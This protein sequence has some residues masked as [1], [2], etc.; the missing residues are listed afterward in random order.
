MA[1]GYPYS[2]PFEDDLNY[3][4]NAVKVVVDAYHGD[5]KFYVVDP[6]D[7]ILRVYREALPALFTDFDEV[8]DD[9]RRH[10]RYPI[11]LFDIQAEKYNIYHMTVPQVFYNGEDMWEEPWETYGGRRIRMQPYYVLVR[12]PGEDRL[13]FL[14]MTPLTPRNRDNMIG[15]MAAR[16]DFPGYGEV[17]VYKL[18]KDHLVIGP[19][20]IEALINQDTDISQRLSLWDQRGSRVIRGNLLVI[21]I[22]NSFIYVEP[23]YLISEGTDIPQLKRIIVSDGEKL[24]MERTLE[25]ALKAVFGE[26]RPR[27]T[28]ATVDA[29]AADPE[30]LVGA[31]AAYSEVEAALR[32]GDWDAFGRA[33]EALGSRLG[34]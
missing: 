21:P 12:L 25:E 28:D 2:E 22:E 29:R 15:W 32:A 6:E 23:V 7:P 34:E 19:I 13:Q 10:L 3:I 18:P 14:L 5:V 16:S 17:L 1:S 30:D 26:E 31:R 8:P 20:Q 33:M 27:T 11:D 4:R 9:L 24:A